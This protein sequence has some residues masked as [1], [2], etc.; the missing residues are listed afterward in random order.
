MHDYEGMT[1]GTSTQQKVKD[2]VKEMT[3]TSY[4]GQVK[5]LKVDIDLI[6]VAIRMELSGD[7]Y[8]MMNLKND[9]AYKY[10]QIEDIMKKHPEYFI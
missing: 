9:V 4:R 8:F 10:Q 6:N 3:D 5:K 7:K 1:Y 2:I